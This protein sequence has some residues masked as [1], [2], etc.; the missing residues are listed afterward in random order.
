MCIVVSGVFDTLSPAGKIVNTKSWTMDMG[1]RTIFSY[2]Y[3][4]RCASTMGVKTING[5]AYA[6]V[7]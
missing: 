6:N 1:A 3:I 4:V 2:L 5:F 7:T